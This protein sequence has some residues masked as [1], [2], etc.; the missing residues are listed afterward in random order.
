MPHPKVYADFQNLDDSN[1]IRLTTQGTLA[2]LERQGIELHEG[3]ELT[4]YTDDE[5]DSGDRIELQAEAVAK[6]DP[7]EA[8]WVA[9]IDW[10]AIRHAGSH[11]VLLDFRRVSVRPDHRSEE[12]M[13]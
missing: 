8:L 1:R 4:L 9:T 11:G 2:D 6:F 7:D 13:N 10:S 5:D 12:M 3:L